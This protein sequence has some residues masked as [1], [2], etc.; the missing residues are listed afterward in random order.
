MVLTLISWLLK[1]GH[2]DLGF[3]G[4]CISMENRGFLASYGCTLL[5]LCLYHFLQ[6]HLCIVVSSHGRLVLPKVK[7]VCPFLVEKNSEHFLFFGENLA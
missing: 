3:V 1:K 7:C 2:S 6:N 5:I 4:T